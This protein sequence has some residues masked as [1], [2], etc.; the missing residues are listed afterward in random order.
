MVTLEGSY[1]CEVCNWPDLL[2]RIKGMGMNGV[3]SGRSL[4]L[5]ALKGGRSIPR[6]KFAIISRA[7][8]L[9]LFFFI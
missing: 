4:R 6:R 8:S 3:G 1:E 5:E 7:S 2:E 9:R